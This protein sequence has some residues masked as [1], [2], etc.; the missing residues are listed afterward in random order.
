MMF[1]ISDTDTYT[2]TYTYT[3]I[4]SLSDCASDFE[5]TRKSLTRALSLPNF[6]FQPFSQLA[7]FDRALLNSIPWFRA[8]RHRKTRL[9]RTL[10][11]QQVPEVHICGQSRVKVVRWRC[12]VLRLSSIDGWPGLE[13]GSPKPRGFLHSAQSSPGHQ[14]QQ[15][16]APE[17]Q[18]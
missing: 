11:A 5:T 10:F 15:R 18:I 6:G 8:V 3:I 1:Q 16:Q 9:L 12:H 7:G 14:I 2:Y 4:I 13:G 17:V